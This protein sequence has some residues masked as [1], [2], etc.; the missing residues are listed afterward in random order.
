M[1]RENRGSGLPLRRGQRT[2]N[3]RT[4]LI[5][6][7][8]TSAATGPISQPESPEIPATAKSGMTLSRRYEEVFG[9]FSF[10]YL[11][12][13]VFRRKR[14]L[15]LPTILV[16]AAATAGT[17]TMDK[18]YK[19]GTTI[20]VNDEEILNPLVKWEAAVSMTIGDRLKTFS[21]IIYSRTL[22]E[23]AID[24]IGLGGA[25]P[26][27]MERLMLVTALRE[28]ITTQQSG[29]DSFQIEAEWKDATLAKEIAETVTELFV[30]KSLEAGRRTAGIAV[31]FIQSQLENYEERL[32]ESEERLKVYKEKNPKRLPSQ[33]SSYLS[34]LKSYDSKMVELEVDIKERSLEIELLKQRLSGEQPMIVD[35]ATF[36]TN[37]P[38]QSEFFRL[39]I[40]LEGML[41]E[42]KPD[43]PDVV[44]VKDELSA[45]K[46]LL[47]EEKD[48]NEATL[49]REVMSPVYQQIKANLQSAEIE[50]EGMI[51]QKNEFE[52]IV[53]DLEEKVGQIPESEMVLNTLMREAEIN[54][55]LFNTL[56][57]KS[58]QA[59]ITREVEI[60]SQKNRFQILDPAMVPLRHHKPNEK[61]IIIAGLIGGFF[62]GFCL[63][64]VFEYLDPSIVREEEV[65]HVFGDRVLARVP[66]LFV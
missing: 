1:V 31:D 28:S 52:K 16:A 27:P 8:A 21:K 15:I 6:K 14:F 9:L 23:N 61:L 66:K 37:T 36:N 34:E 47:D 32:A 45:I 22:L 43:H 29:S 41:Q 46:K 35:A 60:E 4:D 57:V 58:A 7:R 50:L 19:S 65:N 2:A 44:R 17:F 51:L 53:T 18:S 24:R 54:R 62:L 3:R 11:I 20:L 39:T 10:K 13:I 38:Y 48:A 30:D 33:H 63:I 64:F 59:R 26:T 55:E 49:K 40:L 42:K 5:L 25:N 12:S 56:K